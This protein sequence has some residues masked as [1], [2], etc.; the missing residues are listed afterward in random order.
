MLKMVK[1]VK[2]VKMVKIPNIYSPVQELADEIARGNSM[3][4]T[5]LSII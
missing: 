2:L 4:L 5:L 1:M 3:S